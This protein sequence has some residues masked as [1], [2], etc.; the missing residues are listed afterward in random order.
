MKKVFYQSAAI[1]LFVI[2]FAQVNLASGI[3]GYQP[4]LP[5]KLKR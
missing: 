1:L 3:W 5:E 2:S 4:M